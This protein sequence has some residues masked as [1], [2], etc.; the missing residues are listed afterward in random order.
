M[1]T[2]DRV[3]EYEVLGKLGQGAMGVVYRA[4]H[5]LMNREAAI[6][7]VADSR[8]A[9]FAK[10]FR[11]EIEVSARVAHPNVAAVFDA[12]IHHGEP[13]LVSEYLPGPDLREAGRDHAAYGLPRLLRI[14]A[15][16]ADAIAAIHREDVVH[17]DVK[18]SNIRL[19]GQGA[20]KIFDFGIAKLAER[21]DDIYGIA[22]APASIPWSGSRS[23][24]TDDATFVDRVMQPS[25]L[26]TLAGPISYRGPDV[27]DEGLS[28]RT[29]P[30]ADETGP[31]EP[32]RDGEPEGTQSNP[33]ATRIVGVVGTPMYMAPEQ[34]FDASNVDHRADVYSLGCT[35]FYLFTGLSI[36]DAPDGHAADILE[37]KRVGD[38]LRLADVRPDCPP[39]LATVLEKM[40]APDP[41]ARFS[42]MDRARQAIEDIGESPKIFLSYRRQDTIDATDRLYCLLAERFGSDAVYMDV[43]SIPAGSDFRDHIRDAVQSC[44][45][46]LVVIGDH[47]LGRDVTDSRRRIDDDAD[48]VRLEIEAAIQSGI[49]VI[50]VLVGMA[51]MPRAD[52]LPGSIRDLAFFNATA[53]R[54][55]TGYLLSADRLMTGINDL[56][57]AR[58]TARA[59]DL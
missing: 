53:L 17:R 21:G 45:V 55:G 46:L 4:H 39:G 48:F 10:L 9:P 50:P 59:A 26:E 22:G 42:S 40:V 49:P 44:D 13:Y 5:R 20:P 33:D 3:G 19:D 7:V 35:L 57:R 58:A 47:W 51:E 43:D 16:V 6:K 28:E 14:A 1:K 15:Q 30:L 32:M 54:S 34:W 41:D 18:P 37:K 27:S 23:H 52:D 29:F 2:G 8:I 24:A 36:V 38:T 31:A 11:R 56:W 25:A 12:G